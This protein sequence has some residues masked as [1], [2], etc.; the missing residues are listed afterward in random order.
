MSYVWSNWNGRPLPFPVVAKPVAPGT[1]TPVTVPSAREPE[2][3]PAS[4]SQPTRPPTYSNPRT[5]PLA[6]DWLMLPALKPTS[7]PMSKLAFTEPV[8]VTLPLAPDRAI[9][10]SV[11]K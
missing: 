7:P 8:P 3:V 2:M 10:L 9:E 5:A 6:V 11:F 1:V 4:S